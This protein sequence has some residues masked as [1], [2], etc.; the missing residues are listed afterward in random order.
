MQPPSLK[1]ILKVSQAFLSENELKSPS[2]YDLKNLSFRCLKKR[3]RISIFIP[4]TIATNFRTAYSC[5]LP[6]KDCKKT[7]EFSTLVTIEIL[8]LQK[9]SSILPNGGK[10]YPDTSSASLDLVVFPNTW[11][12]NNQINWLEPEWFT[13]R[14]A[15]LKWFC[16]VSLVLKWILTCLSYPTV[17]I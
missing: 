12:L 5:Q 3:A 10:D 2:V 14:N 13:T 1:I 8:S 16:N 9:I 6:N 17:V 11:F 4:Y 7:L 15:Q